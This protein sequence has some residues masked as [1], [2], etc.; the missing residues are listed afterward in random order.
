VVTG[1]GGP[2]LMVG[3]LSVKMIDVRKIFAA[4]AA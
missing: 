4:D 2:E 3:D 1:A